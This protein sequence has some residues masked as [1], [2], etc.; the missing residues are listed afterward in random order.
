MCVSNTTSNAKINVL[1]ERERERERER[2]GDGVGD[3]Y[4]NIA[5][6]AT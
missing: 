5:G 6:K 3:Y 2:E 1:I 4:F